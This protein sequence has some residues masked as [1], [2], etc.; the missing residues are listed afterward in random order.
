M[1]GVI[2]VPHIR[3]TCLLLFIVSLSACGP[4][5]IFLRPALDTPEQHVKNGNNLMARGKLDAANTEFLR[6]VDLDEGYVAAYV[7]LALVQGYRG[8][9]E[10]GLA[11]LQKAEAYVSK[12][13]EQR[14]VEQGYE[15][16]MKMK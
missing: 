5:T 13:E 9:V 12:P 10:A 4:D 11:T 3:F 15:K 7:G 2:M 6:A 14:S 8:D 1:G 16:L